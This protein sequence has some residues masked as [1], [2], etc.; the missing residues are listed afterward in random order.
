MIT[1]SMVNIDGV[2]T[3]PKVPNLFDLAIGNQHGYFEVFDQVINVKSIENYEL[4]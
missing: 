1:P 3:P 2:N 4:Q